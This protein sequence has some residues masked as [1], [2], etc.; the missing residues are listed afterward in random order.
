MIHGGRS[1]VSGTCGQRER[2]RVKSLHD[3]KR[4]VNKFPKEKS[5][6]D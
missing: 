3:S 2:V 4:K 1:Q 5:S 6:E